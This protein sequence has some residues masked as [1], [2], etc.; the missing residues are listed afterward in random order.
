M[1]V[2]LV[3]PPRPGPSAPPGSAWALLGLRK[4][5]LLAGNHRLATRHKA[6]I[7][8]SAPHEPSRTGLGAW[9]RTWVEWP[10]AGALLKPGTH[11]ISKHPPH[12]TSALDVE[13]S[14][15]GPPARRAEEEG[16]LLLVQLPATSQR[17]AGAPT[18]ALIV[19]LPSICS[20][21]PSLSC[22]K[23]TSASGWHLCF[24]TSPPPP[25][26][27]S[28]SHLYFPEKRRGSQ[29]PRQG[30]GYICYTLPSGSLRH[31]W[32][33]LTSDGLV[34]HPRLCH[35]LSVGPWVSCLSS[36]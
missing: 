15:W 24:L 33:K 32:G 20:L 10:Q 4:Q 22:A 11:P 36:L 7:K 26:V 34:Y 29:V 19:H 12:P 3:G 1:G 6:K 13:L 30:K 35:L 18:L 14:P 31:S 16:G 2:G 9:A 28:K 27:L 23:S 17:V 21:S 25:S 5:K 8:L